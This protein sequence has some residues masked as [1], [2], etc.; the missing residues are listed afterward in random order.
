MR[1]E[2]LFAVLG[3]ENLRFA[4]LRWRLAVVPVS[5]MKQCPVVCPQAEK[6]SIDAISPGGSA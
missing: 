1:R 2:N 4:H 3:S 5:Q 6:E